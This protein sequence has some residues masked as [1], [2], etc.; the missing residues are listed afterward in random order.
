MGCECH[1]VAA[2]AQWDRRGGCGPPRSP[3]ETQLEA[4][5]IVLEAALA[6]LGEGEA[7]PPQLPVGGAL[8]ET[9]HL[10]DRCGISEKMSDA[11]TGHVPANVARGYGAPTLADMAAAMRKF[12]RYEV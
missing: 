3:V 12:P 7:V 6:G 8:D 1:S 9:D 11:I 2:G 5:H 10:V 4:G